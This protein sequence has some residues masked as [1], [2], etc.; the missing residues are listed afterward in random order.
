MNKLNHKDCKIGNIVKYECN[1]GEIK[2]DVIRK[3]NDALI[4]D[5]VHKKPIYYVWNDEIIE[6]YSKEKKSGV[7]PMRKIDEDSILK[8]GDKLLW[9]NA[10]NRREFFGEFSVVSIHHHG[11]EWGL[12]YYLKFPDN[13]I[14][15]YMDNI[16]ISSNCMLLDK[17]KEPEYFL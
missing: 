2:I 8:V 6:F 5:N 12:D 1:T 17:E 16:T 9:E 3:I 4:V 11:V 13:K 15:Q 14:P 7:F 10:D